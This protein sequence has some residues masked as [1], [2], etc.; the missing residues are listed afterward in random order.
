MIDLQP[1]KHAKPLSFFLAT[2]KKEIKW[3]AINS[4]FYSLGT[5][6]TLAVPYFLGKIVDDL[7]S[8]GN[9]RIAIILFICALFGTELFY[10]I[11]HIFE[12]TVD[13]R[14]RAATK[15]A[16]FSYSTK[17]SFGYFSDRFAGQIAHQITTAADALE[18]MKDIVVNTFIDNTWMLI[19]SAITL[20]TIY[21]LLGAVIVV[22]GALFI[23]GLSPITKKITKSAESFAENASHTTGALVDMYTN[24]STVKLYSKDSD[25]S[26]IYT[27]VN[28]EYA[29]QLSLGKWSV[30]AYA[31]QGILGVLLG[32]ALLV[33]TAYGYGKG[34]ITIGQIVLIMGVGMKILDNIY[35]IGHTIS[36]F[37]RSRGEC[38]QALKDILIKPAI[39]DGAEKLK[40]S[41]KSVA[42]IMERITFSYGKNKRVL[43]NFSLAIPSGQKLGIVGLSG[44]GKTTL[45]NLLIRFFD[46]QSGTISINGIDTKTISQEALR[47]HI[48]FISQD[49]SLFHAT[50]A[51]N[52]QYGSPKVSREKLKKVAKMAYADEFIRE[53]PKDYYTIVGERG[54]KLSGGQRQRIAIARAMLKNSPLF[55]LDEA[56]SALDSESE[57]KI[58]VALKLLMEG[59][60][61]IAIAHRLSTLQ[62]MDRIVFIEHGRVVED[63]SHEELL[64]RGGKYATLWSMQAGGFLPAT[65]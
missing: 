48:S 18:R 46:P 35:H 53:L 6:A 25:Q 29:S 15:K 45:V 24:I 7:T 26:R 39:D 51:E 55:L 32:V 43:K 30:F 54:V 16:L 40:N 20:A 37:V 38:S 4:L 61:V 11:G 65:L 42:I 3:M 47:S 9:E 50:I 5:L 63:G 13:A 58:Q 34:L 31:Y 22:W 12:V 64:S 60:T 59:K 23:F 1:Q 27:K 56:T 17:L 57:A 2:N 41:W 28:K 19:L 21:P 62:S 44:A 8:G 14:I 10:R 36:D 33:I 49:T 52:I